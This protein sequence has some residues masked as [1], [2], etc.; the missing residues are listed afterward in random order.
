MKRRVR[1]KCLGIAGILTLGKGNRDANLLL[2]VYSFIIP[3]YT[4]I[5][6]NTL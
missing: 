4:W 2:K 5:K 6:K 1:E 3:V